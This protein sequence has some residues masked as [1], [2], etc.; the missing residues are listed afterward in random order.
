MKAH[1][2]TITHSLKGNNKAK[3]KKKR[4][5]S[6]SCHFCGMERKLNYRKYLLSV[7]LFKKSLTINF[8][9]GCM[10]VRWKHHL[11]HKKPFYFITGSVTISFQSH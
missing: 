4:E 5:L 11:L 3:K 8:H 2:C 6:K 7:Y 9:R 1:V 10:C